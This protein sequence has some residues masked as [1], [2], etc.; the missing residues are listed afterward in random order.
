[1]AQIAAALQVTP[2]WIYDRIR[3]G[4]IQVVRDAERNL[5]LFPDR[6]RTVTLFKQL[7]AGK[8]QHLRF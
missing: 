5:Y 2:N 6:P 8:L 1:M 3:N 7:Q 4:T